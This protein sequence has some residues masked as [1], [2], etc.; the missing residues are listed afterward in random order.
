MSYDAPRISF[1]HG[2]NLELLSGSDPSQFGLIFPRD[3]DKRCSL[4][5]L[6]RIFVCF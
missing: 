4:V 1:S 5:G 2:F 3:L 6:M